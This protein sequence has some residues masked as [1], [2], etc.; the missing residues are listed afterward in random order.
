MPQFTLVVL[1]CYTD[2]DWDGDTEDRRSITGWCVFIGDCLISWG[3]KSQRNV[4]TSS[5]E[6]EYVGISEICKEILFVT[7]MLN[8]LNQ[9]VELPVTILVDNVG[10]IY[11]AENAVTKRTKHIDTRYH[12]IREYVSDGIVE[13]KFVKSIDNVAD[14]F[15]KNVTEKIYEKFESKLV[16]NAE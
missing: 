7:Y 3:L 5:T 1:R 8:I 9:K 11:I 12:V 14:I 10:A 16:C 15:T 6:A 2:S 4:T 13:L